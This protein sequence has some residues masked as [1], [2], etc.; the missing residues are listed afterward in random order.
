MSEEQ[1][2]KEKP[3][4][5]ILAQ[6]I[7]RYLPFWPIYIVLTVIALIVAYIYL[8]AET[9]IYVATA[10][11][12]L[13]DPQKGGGDSKVLD[14]LNIFSEKKIVENEIIVLRSSSL[15]Q[16]V[17][18]SLNL[19]A[20]V[21]NQGKVQK[22]ELYGSNSPVAFV[23]LQKDSIRGGG[24]YE[25]DIDWRNERVSIA[26]KSVPFNGIIQ[27]AKT[28]YQVVI[29]PEYSR[30]LSGKNYYVVFSTVQTAAARV[31]GTLKATPLSYA[32]TVIDLRLETPIQEKG[33]NILNKLFEVYNREGIEDKNQIA[34]KT[35][36]FIED[37]LNTVIGQ[38]DSVE[39]IIQNYKARQGVVDLGIQ[40]SMY[41]SAV[42]D[43]DRQ[44]AR[45][46][47]QMDILKD[48]QQYV[49]RKSKNPG[50]VPSLEVVDDPTL[51]SLLEQ[52]YNSEFELD[53][54][55][56][57]AGNKSELVMVAEEKVF[58]IKKD[59]QENLDNIRSNFNTELA[60]INNAIANKYSLLSLVPEKE[61]GLLE[62]NRQQSIKNNIYTFLLQK[63][64]E[65]A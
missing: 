49:N 61:R 2:F 14:A 38:L 36:A 19:Y 53:R 39:R 13:K 29:N 44:K 17:V 54:I 1:F 5:N 9:K 10:K 34:T 59:I 8:R 12:L 45:V 55:R 30:N 28:D 37:R 20:T 52:L 46:E 58:R 27:I 62:I 43:L 42:S 31:I 23:A 33:I 24:R 51:K 32:S 57:T 60:Q 11:V 25:F 65:T 7:H 3:S 18:K 15:M 48:I 41:Y 4:N 21:Y 22:E 26:G 63:R 64:E 50:V 16:Q 56:S 47:L 40:A 35:L 6:I